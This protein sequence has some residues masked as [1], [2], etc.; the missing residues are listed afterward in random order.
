MI[1]AAA[2]YA[3]LVASE[4]DDLRLYLLCGALVGA[5][6]AVRLNGLLTGLVLL[7]IHLW[8]P[9]SEAE[10]EGII[11]R[12]FVRVRNPRLW[13]SGLVAVVTLVAIQPSII[14]DPGRL[15]QAV[16]PDD[17]AYSVSVARGEFLRVWSLVGV[18]T[19]PYLYFW[20]TLWPTAVGWPLTLTFIASIGHALWRPRWQT[21]LLVLWLVLY[22]IPI[23]GLHTKHV[24]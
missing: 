17:L 20:S 1:A 22:F 5:A 8:R 21:S 19:I 13:L 12:L 10:K 15:T 3:I 7:A 2:V 18:H 23:G 4:R 11:G 16:T 24:R 9:A 6:G 14:T